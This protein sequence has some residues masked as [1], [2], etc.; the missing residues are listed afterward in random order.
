M[1][2]KIILL[3]V[4]IAGILVVSLFGFGIKERV[5]KGIVKDIPEY[6]CGDNNLCTSC[7]IEGHTCSCGK[8]SCDCGNKTVDRSECSLYVAQ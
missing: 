5:L 4:I 8:H 7:I 1:R 6:N 3:I 2:T